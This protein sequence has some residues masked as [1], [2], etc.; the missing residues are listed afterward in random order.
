MDFVMHGKHTTLTQTLSQELAEDLDMMYIP[1]ASMDLIYINP[2][3][4]DMRQLDPQLPDA[5]K[6]FDEKDFVRSPSHPNAPKFQFDI[7]KLKLGQYVDALA[8]VLNTGKSVGCTFNNS[9][10]T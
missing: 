6:S 3:G 9:L 8:H 5:C 1:A 2:Y 4:Y 10:S 7:F